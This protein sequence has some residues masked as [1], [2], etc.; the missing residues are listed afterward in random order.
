MSSLKSSAPI[1][2]PAVAGKPP[3][4]RLCSMAALS[5]LTCQPLAEWLRNGNGGLLAAHQKP[6]SMTS[7]VVGRIGGTLSTTVE[8]LAGGH[9]VGCRRRQ[10]MRCESTLANSRSRLN[11]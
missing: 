8:R 2:P 4:R 3:L 1:V 6:P 7:S 9:A 10:T 5:A 11:A